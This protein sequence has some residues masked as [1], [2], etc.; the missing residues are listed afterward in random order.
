MSLSPRSRKTITGIDLSTGT[1]RT[2][3]FACDCDTETM[4]A[5]EGLLPAAARHRRCLQRPVTVIM[6]R[7]DDVLLSRHDFPGLWPT[8]CDRNP[9]AQP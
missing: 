9:R 7:G 5:N 3:D 6:F 2:L 1:E 4:V 8:A